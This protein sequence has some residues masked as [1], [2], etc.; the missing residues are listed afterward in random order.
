[1]S[2]KSFLLIILFPPPPPIMSTI[3]NHPVPICLPDAVRSS[4]EEVV[5]VRGFERPLWSARAVDLNLSSA[6]Y[7]YHNLNNDRVPPNSAHFVAVSEK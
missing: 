6:V 3:F 1:M 2:S 4:Q 5:G 7:P